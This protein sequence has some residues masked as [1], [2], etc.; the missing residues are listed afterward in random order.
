V[1]AAQHRYSDPLTQTGG[2]AQRSEPEASQ[3]DQ[4]HS[5]RTSRDRARSSP[6]VAPM[7]ER[8][9]VAT[10]DHGGASAIP[11]GALSRSLAPAVDLHDVSRP[12]RR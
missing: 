1:A 10:R 4:R 7:V 9:V 8:G 3:P 12:G 11:L 2:S 5:D 6:S